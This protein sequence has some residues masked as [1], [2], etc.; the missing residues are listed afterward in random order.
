MSEL[1]IPDAA[2]DAGERQVE[3]YPVSYDDAVEL[4]TSVLKAAGPMIV[5]AELR[6]LADA[7]SKSAEHQVWLLS[8]IFDRIDAL[9]PN[10]LTR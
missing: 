2:H 9:D 7:M 3:P 4:V 1:E 5:A 8:P 6:L 10:G